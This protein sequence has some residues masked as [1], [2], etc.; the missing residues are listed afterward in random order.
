MCQ[1]LLITETNEKLSENLS[2]SGQ[3]CQTILIIKLDLHVWF[4][5][6]YSQKY[7]QYM[8]IMHA[9]SDDPVKQ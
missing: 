9:H 6:I 3:Y 2:V 7:K 5:V 4:Y 1:S 8:H